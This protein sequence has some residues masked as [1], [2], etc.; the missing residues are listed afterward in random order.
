MRA[1]WFAS[2]L[3]ALVLALPSAHAQVLPAFPGAEGFGAKATGG[4]GGQVLRVTNLGNNAKGRFCSVDGS[5]APPEGSLQWALDQPGP[6]VIV[7]AVGGIIEGDIRVPHGDV[8]IAGQTAP[9]GITIHG[10]LCA[11]YA[12]RPDA[13]QFG[14]QNMIIRHLRVRPPGTSSIWPA[15]QHDAIQF[16]SNDLIILDHIDASHG[17]DEIVDLHGF[18]AA[19]GLGGARDV[20]VQWSIIGNSL[21]DPDHEGGHNYG[22]ISGPGAA[23]V[24]IHHNLFGHNRNRNPAIAFGPAESINNV[25]YNYREGFTHNNTPNGQFNIVGNYFKEGPQQHNS[26]LWF[27]SDD[28]NPQGAYYLAS[29]HVDAPMD[30]YQDTLAGNPFD[31][32]LFSSE[33]FFFYGDAGINSTMFDYHQ[34]FDFSLDDPLHVPVSTTPPIEAY[35]AVL[36]LAGAWP[37]D[38]YATSLVDDTR[39]RAGGYELDPPDPDRLSACHDIG[40]PP[41]DVDEDGMADAW[42]LQHGLDPT[43]ASDNVSVRPSGYMAIEAYVNDLA[44]SLLPGTGEPAVFADGFET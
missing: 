29:N 20:T 43:D 30:G 26:P 39:E 6:R 31:D 13:G 28:D 41:T 33:F 42:E 38:C 14:P 12:S 22:L 11:E 8:T 19:S 34:P 32:P 7:F 27:D 25:A 1:L 36:D 35:D 44:E 37:R 2:A 4:R 10:H 24:S 23:R 9:G 18:D 15:P 21:L 40:T 5:G 16:S 17:V 3:T